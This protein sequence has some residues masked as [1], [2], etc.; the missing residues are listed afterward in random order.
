MIVVRIKS[1]NT[2][3]AFSIVPGT[4]QGSVNGNC[5]SLSI[6][7]IAQYPKLLIFFLHLCQLVN[8]QM[9]LPVFCGYPSAFYIITIVTLDIHGLLCRWK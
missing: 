3:N 8:N 2:H 7:N 9:L 6:Y 5:Y 1:D 4:N